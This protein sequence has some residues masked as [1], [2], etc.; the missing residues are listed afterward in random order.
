MKTP[1]WTRRV[2][3]GA[4]GCAEQ[5]GSQSESSAC[6]PGLLDSSTADI[7]LWMTLC[8]GVSPRRSRM[9]SST[10]GLYPLRAGSICPQSRN[11]QKYLRH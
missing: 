11:K 5:D 8:F 3:R 1:D 9:F 10:P 6:S 7:L 2:P 4:S